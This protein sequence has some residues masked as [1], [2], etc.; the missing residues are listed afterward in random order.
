M[1]C[2]AENNAMGAAVK[3]KPR[4]LRGINSLNDAIK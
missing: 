2:H 3:D 1:N 4:S